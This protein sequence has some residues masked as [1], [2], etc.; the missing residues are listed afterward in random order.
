MKKTTTAGTVLIIASLLAFTAC[1]KKDKVNGDFPQQS[2]GNGT[3]PDFVYSSATLPS[4]KDADGILGAVNSYNYRIATLSPMS[5]Y[6]E[7]GLAGFTNT[8]GN[9]SAL[10]DAGAITVDTSALAKSS[11]MMYQS[12]PTTYSL[13]FNSAPISW[14]V[15]GAGNMPASAYTIPTGNNPSYNYFE[16]QSVYWK[17][18]WTPIAQGSSVTYSIPVK[19]YTSNADTVCFIF[20]DGGSYYFE[21]KVPATDSIA[22]FTASDFANVSAAADLTTLTFEINAVKYY[23]VTV[24]TKKYYF[25]RMDA[26]KK[27]WQKL[28]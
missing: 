12:H 25:L 17:D 11:S 23:P 18:E 19:N 28:Y 21:K 27:Y 14:N 22:S 20:K 9:F 10:T 1:K 24:G 8:T 4:I 26:H 5:A 6:F 13:N 16:G 15:A 7:Y 3:S 2:V